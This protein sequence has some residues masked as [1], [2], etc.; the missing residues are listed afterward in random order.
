MHS[1][2]LH[3]NLFS[4]SLFVVQFGL[5]SNQLPGFVRPFVSLT[6]LLLPFLFMV[7][8]AITMP[9]AMQL[10]V[11]VL[12]LQKK[13]HT[14]TL[15][16]HAILLSSMQVQVCWCGGFMAT[17]ILIGFMQIFNLII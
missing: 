12:R 5:Q 17:F 13:K 14:C 2:F 1:R 8:K 16:L 4:M 11:L 10:N 9:L 7:V 15:Q 6:A 3:L